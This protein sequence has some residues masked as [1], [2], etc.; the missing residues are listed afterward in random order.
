[1]A[2]TKTG[3]RV[4]RPG[5]KTSSGG[6]AGARKT[7]GKKRGGKKRSAYHHGDLSRALIDATLELIEERGSESFTLREVARRVGVSEAAPYRHFKDKRA[8]LAS[9]AA[10]GF[11]NLVDRMVEAGEGAGDDPLLRIRNMG[12]EYVRFAAEQRHRFAVM[13]GPVMAD[14]ADYPELDAATDRA[15]EL[16][17]GALADCQEAGIFAAGDLR[18]TMLAAWSLVHGLAKLETEGLIRSILDEPPDIEELVDQVNQVF[19]LGIAPRR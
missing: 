6:K 1:M 16:F 18:Y 5:R 12:L 17:L 3:S 8:L 19:F 11:R 10:D 9:V 15:Q 2:T 7:A 13:T 14:R 4:A